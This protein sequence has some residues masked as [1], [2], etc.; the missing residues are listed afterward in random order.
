MAGTG[1]GKFSSTAGNNTSNMTVNFAENMAP[2]NVNNAAR[3]LMAHIY[4]MYKQLGD[5]YFEYGDGDATYTVA[6]TDADT[7]TITSASDI[8]SIYFPGRKI[9]ITDGG[10]NV[11]EG[12]IA[13][14]SHASTTQTV[15]LTGISLAAGTPTKVE[16]GIDTAAFGGRLILDDDGDSYIEA[17]TDDTIDFYAGGTKI[18][19]FTA[20]TVDFNDGVTIT[21]ADN[22]DNLTLTTTDADG[23][24]GPNLRLYRNSASPADNDDLGTI[25]FEGRNDNSQDVQYGM[26]R[27]ILKDA[28]DGSEDGTL[29]FHHMKNGSLAPSLQITP[30]ECVINESSNDYDFRVESNG[31][32]NMFHINGGSN[33]VGIGADPDLGVGLHIKS[34]DSG[35]SS[36]NAN[37]DELV[38]EGSGNSG[39]TILSGTSSVGG[40]AFGDSGGNLQGLIQYSHANDQ[41]EFNVNSSAN[42]MNISDSKVTVT[43]LEVNGG[44]VGIGETSPNAKLHIKSS[45]VGAFTPFV[46]GDDLIIEGGEAGLGFMVGTADSSNIS[47]GDTAN[48]KAG[49]INYDHSTDNM[50]F[51]TSDSE[52]MLIKA[53]GTFGFGRTAAQTAQNSFAHFYGGEHSYFAYKFEN[54]ETATNSYTMQIYN[55]YAAD[56]NSSEFFRCQDGGANRLIIFADGDVQNH[57]NAYGSLSDERIKQDIRDSNSQWDDIKAVRVR[58]FKKKDD[59]RQYGDDAWEQIGVVAQE[60]EAV[61]PKLVRQGDPTASDILS[62]SSFGTLWTADDPETQDGVE[63]VLYTADDPETQDVLYTAD[64]VETQDVLYTEEDE[65]PEGV[66]VGDVKE[67]ASASVGDVK[68]Q[69]SHNVGDVKIEAKPSTKQIGEVKEINEQVKSVNYSILY[70]K[71]VKALQE[72]MDRIETLESKVATLEGE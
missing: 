10:A 30:D 39:M 4:D 8:S 16:L 65:L 18:G 14:S 62:D 33:I 56:D 44:N 34:G 37:R 22:S 23:S 20:T 27:A 72:A 26:I 17:P 52:R 49:R 5:G 50:R 31:N 60:L 2:S 58:N 3:E 63:E 51:F 59:V 70:M 48:A 64:D 6:R 11:V 19:T 13:S 47:F 68:T 43:E 67:P 36:A 66:E 24:I 32:A 7:I 38:I 9:R 55:N 42:P 53:G 54:A 28:S 1:V 21:V 35:Q 25:D 45:D 12:T 46:G 40:I 15:N 71:A 29:E 57:D 69:A 41:F 61:S